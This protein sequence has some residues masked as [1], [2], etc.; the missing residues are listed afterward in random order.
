MP[1]S[2]KQ[3]LAEIIAELNRA[4]RLV[5]ARSVVPLKLFRELSAH[6]SRIAGRFLLRLRLADRVERDVAA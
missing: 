5:R 6:R 4:M 1:P 2:E 3:D